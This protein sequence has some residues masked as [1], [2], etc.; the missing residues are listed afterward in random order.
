MRKV[1]F[2]LAAAVLL[3]G[4]VSAGSRNGGSNCALCTV[5]MALIEQTALVNA[6]PVLSVIRELCAFLPFPYDY[7]CQT[8]IDSY[9]PQLIE[10]LEAKETPDVICNTIEWC[11]SND[12]PTCHIFPLPNA[13]S[14]LL[15]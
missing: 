3:V 5:A 9:G 1:F 15:G 14:S 12:G 2:G 10:L 11:N 13:T 7:T 8:V 6:L 4:T